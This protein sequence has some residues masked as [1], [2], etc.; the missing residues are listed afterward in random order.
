MSKRDLSLHTRNCRNQL[1]P[2]FS[3]ELEDSKKFDK[4]LKMRTNMIGYT[5]YNCFANLSHFALNCC[6]LSITA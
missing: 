1:M 3:M 6:E 4:L 5:Y 2:N